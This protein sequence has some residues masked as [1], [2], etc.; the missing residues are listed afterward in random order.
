MASIKMITVGGVSF[1][2]RCAS[3]PNLGEK[4]YIPKGEHKG[5]YTVL[6]V[7]QLAED[8]YEAHVA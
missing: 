1:M 4:L 3:A 2:A 5:R 8:E 7:K 6:A